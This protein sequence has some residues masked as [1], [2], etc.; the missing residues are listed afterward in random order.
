MATVDSVTVVEMS[1]GSLMELA[2]SPDGLPVD[3]SIQQLVCRTLELVDS[4]AGKHS[5]GKTMFED[6]LRTRANL[7]ANASPETARVLMRARQVSTSL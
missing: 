2:A 3:D 6:V 7:V 1:I 5:A 4:H